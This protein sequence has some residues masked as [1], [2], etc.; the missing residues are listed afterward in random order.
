MLFSDTAISLEPVPPWS[1]PTLGPTAM[2]GVA[3]VLAGL[4]LWTYLGV[5]QATW[6]RVLVVLLL[7]LIALALVFGM[8]LRPSLAVTQLDGV[9]TSKL[10][11][12]FDNSASMNVVDMDGKPSRWEQVNQLWASHEV[13]RRLLQLAAEQKIEVV[14]YVAAVDLAADNPQALADGRRSDLGAWLHE[15]WQKHGH[16][17]QV[18][19]IVLFTD[20]ADNGTRFS[21]QDKAR[22]WRGAASI[23]AFGAGDP[24]NVKFKK[25]LGLTDLKARPV[26][27]SVQGELVVEAVVQAPG[28]GKVKV[29]I[30]VWLENV[31]D[32]KTQL[33]KEIKDFEINQEKDQHVIVKG[34][35]PEEQGE[36]KLT[37]KIMPHPDEANK[38]NN[39]IS[40]YVQVIK[41][42]INV[43][44]VD[45]FRVWE[46]TLAIRTLAAEPRFAIRFVTLPAKGIDD[47]HKFYEFAQRHY[48]VIVIGD[49][50]A[51]DFSL[52]NPKIFGTI[53]EMVAKKNTGLLM[54]G[55]PE[56]FCKGGWRKHDEFMSLLPVTFD[57][58]P[59]NAEFS[60][61]EVR[62]AVTPDGL[63]LPFLRLEPSPK[64]NEEMWDG[65]FEPLPGIAPVGTLARDA[66]P[67]LLGRKKELVMA[68]TRT[69][70]AGRVVVF[71]SDSTHSAWRDNTEAV[72]GYNRFWKNLIF[73]LAKEEDNANQLWISL[74]KRRISTDGADMLGFTF[75]LKRKGGF[76]LPKAT[77]T[78]K[79]VHEKR[80]YAVRHVA[81][82]Q[83]QRGSFQGAKEPGE[84]RLVIKGAAKDGDH[85]V[86]AEAV[87]RFLIVSED[88][89]MLR[90]AADHEPL[91]K[92][93]AASDGRFHLAQ[94]Q[95]LLH[96]LDELR[97]QVNRE[98][99]H[100][101]VNWPDWRR[102]PA[103]ES[104]RDQLPALW[105]SFS[106]ASLLIFVG[107][108]SGEWALRRWWGL[109]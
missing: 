25:D 92:I 88:I 9:E 30:G 48:D 104:A 86:Q 7:R 38:D 100:K 99:R 73:W 50:S 103:S 24:S 106:L 82:R 89:E 15:L 79:V 62:L 74:D 39:E 41:S 45:R 13:Q 20:G 81:E 21:A 101:T 66:T 35:A 76:E 46:P 75:G 26:P 78:A 40:T 80:E 32:K 49:V 19:G 53:K 17:K 36:Y 27:V 63:D 11:V 54:L 3:L 6:R 34:I 8:M 96:Y 68:A 57:L 29:D 42:K 95:P 69:G 28:F 23:Q 47:P 87:A 107:L 70:T 52:A 61:A 97:T 85:D 5:K 108:L 2:V 37:M 43:L 14:K 1:A 56:T 44:W 102:L 72:R 105:N 71:A 16:E 18:R 58:P 84:Y 60:N 55:G 109:V 93:V 51:Q 12:I 94:A 59:E 65:K 10:L 22:Q 91:R 98:A 90:P 64:K 31:S 77:F 33:F 67:L 4:T 83:H